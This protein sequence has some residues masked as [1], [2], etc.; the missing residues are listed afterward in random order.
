MQYEH[1]SALRH[2]ENVFGLEE[3]TTRTAAANDFFADCVDMDRLAKGDWAPPIQL[4]VVTPSDW[5]MDAS[6]IGTL[7]EVDDHPILAWANANRE[8]LGDLDL[9]DQLA[10]YKQT[11]ADFLAHPPRA[12][13]KT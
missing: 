5:P 2:L 9:R 11:I 8:L 1:T 12:I 7:R 3:L 6:C 4:P 10:D 13:V